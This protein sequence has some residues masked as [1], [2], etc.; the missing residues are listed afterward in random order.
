MGAASC[1][2]SP[3]FNLCVGFGLAL[4]LAISKRGGSPFVF[5]HDQETPLALAFLVGSCLMTG[6]GVPLCGFH[7]SRRYGVLLICYY[8]VFMTVSLLCEA[9]VL[10]F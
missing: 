6:V 8:V 4:V 5:P 2:G 1:F 7:L 10:R 9:G 3:I